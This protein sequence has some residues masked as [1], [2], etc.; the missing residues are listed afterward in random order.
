MTTSTNIQRFANQQRSRQHN[1][2]STTT[3]TLQPSQT[4]HTL[5]INIHIAMHSDNYSEV[6]PIPLDIQ[7]RHGRWKNEQHIHWKCDGPAKRRERNKNILPEPKW[8]IHLQFRNMGNNL[9]TCLWHGGRH[10]HSTRTQ[11]RHNP[12]TGNQGTLWCSK[13]FFLSRHVCHECNVNTH[14]SLVSLQTR[15]HIIIDNRSHQRTH[16]GQ[17]ARPIG[18]MGVHTIQE[19]YR[20]SCHYHRHLPSCWRRPKAVR[21]NNVCNL[22]LLSLH[23]TSTKT[24]R[25]T[26]P[27]ACNWPR[28]IGPVLSY[29]RR[30]GYC[31]RWL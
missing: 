26:S 7:R 16:T 3:T 22:T 29:E 1:P 23:R 20:P 8:R 15:W 28:G 10:H 12:T 2:S 24:S 31:G 19:E 6:E 14:T 25:E 9:W 17:W 27:T 21:S 4:I 5:M 18:A 13:K 30:M 11:V